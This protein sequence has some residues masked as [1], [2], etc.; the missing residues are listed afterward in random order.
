MA[1]NVLRVGT[2]ASRLALAQTRQVIANLE[3]RNDGLSVELVEITTEGDIDHAS[4]LASMGGEGL[5][6]KQIEQALL[7]NRI[8]VAVHSAKDL[9]STMIPELELAAVPERESPNDV[10]ISHDHVPYDE[11]KSCTII[12]TGSPRR[13]AQ[14]L[15]RH[16]NADVRGI[17][18][19]VETRL[20]KLR[21]GDYN[22]LIMAHAGLKRSGL[23]EAVT[24]VLTFDHMLPAPGQ[25]ALAIQTRAEDESA[26]SAAAT[27]D[28]AE[29]HRML[30][31]ERL[32]MARLGAG[33]ST[34]LGGIARVE[35]GKVVLRVV[36]LD[37]AGE[38]RLDAEHAIAADGDDRALVA[39]VVDQLLNQGAGELIDH[40]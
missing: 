32:L 2:R 13:K 33:C 29:T 27:I 16:R 40:A 8:D 26:V 24:E 36:L 18:G 4:P 1:E 39:E 9:P 14:V 37:D 7:D 20:R 6:T 11:V 12:G 25:G 30:D 15:Y 5:F 10:W 3:A 31:I 34:P 22:G 23:A 38:R 21:D 35:N 17:R 28:H 19:N